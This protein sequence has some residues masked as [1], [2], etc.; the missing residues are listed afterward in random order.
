MNECDQ[1]EK[2]IQELKFE[3]SVSIPDEMQIA[4]ESGDL[5][6]N[7]EFSEVLSRQYYASTRLEN[8]NYR[9]NTCRNI[10]KNISSKSFIQPGSFITVKNIQ[11]KTIE[12]FKMVATEISGMFE[13]K[14]QDITLLSP[15]GKAFVNKKTGDIV[16]VKL[17]GGII[18]K[19]EILDFS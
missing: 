19:Y 8:L 15:L 7:S 13:S 4:M 2:E 5:R 9:L 14:Y 18:V 12:Y 3:L 6:E 10:Y 16:E 17:P 11:N 1:L